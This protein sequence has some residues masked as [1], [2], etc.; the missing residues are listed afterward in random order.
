MRR[1][2]PLLLALP[3]ALAGALPGAARAQ[4]PE[5]V[6]VAVE[7]L[8]GEH[9]ARLE[10]ALALPSGPGRERASRVALALL[11]APGRATP[12]EVL[13]ATLAAGG[14]SPQAARA[15]FGPHLGDEVAAAW[16]SPRVAAA[17][18]LAELA[19][20]TADAAAVRRAREAHA[21]AH[22][23]DAE[24]GRALERSIDRVA[25]RIDPERAVAVKV[26]E[27]LAF[28]RGRLS[29]AE[30][31]RFAEAVALARYAHAGQTRDGG[32]PALLHSLRVARAMLATPG[33]EPAAVHAAVLH[34]VVEDT[35]V[36]RSE[37][38]RRLG[39]RVSELVHAVT[40]DPIERFGGDKLARDRAYYARFAASP[41]GARWL[42][43][44][45]RI[46]NINDMSGWPPEGQLRYLARTRETVVEALRAH[47]PAL[48]ARLEAELQRVEARV[49]RQLAREAPRA[50]AFE[51]HRRPDGSLRWGEVARDTAL[52]EGAGLLRF[53]MAMFL[54]ELAVVARTGDRLRVEEFFEG[55]LTTDFLVHYG[56]FTVGARAG[57]V[58][59]SRAL[60]RHLKPGFVGEVL[61]ANVSLAA[62]LL[63]ADLASGTFDGQAFALSVAALGL[64]STAVRAGVSGLRWVR[65]LRSAGTVARAGG[66]AGFVYSVLETTVV[67][68]LADAIEERAREWLDERAARAALTEAGRAFGRDVAAATSPDE[69][70][71]AAAR[72]GD[73]WTA[74]RDHLL[75]GA[76]IEDARLRERL[77]KIARRAKLLDD[78]RRAA[79][80]ALER[81]PALRDDAVRRH[82]SVDAWAE[83][84]AAEDEARVRADLEAALAAHTRA[85]DAITAA[86]YGAPRRAAPLLDGVAHLP[87]LLLGAAAGAPGDP[88]GDR[89]D[90]LARWGRDRARAGLDRAHG[91]ASPNRLQ[92]YDDQAAVLAAAAAAL[93]DRP[94]APPG[95]AEALD[96]AAARALRARDLEAG[97]AGAGGP[98][99][100][101]LV[102]A[103]E[104]R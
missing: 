47:S 103:L 18:A 68:Y 54:K 62:G 91:R 94:G 15:R 50:A 28:S 74:W 66:V 49:R 86:A 30:A 44:H 81:A 64:S 3:L 38:T 33:V 100:R 5:V 17:V 101:G 67:L 90:V 2:A 1:R 82:G 85:V 53:T 55:I 34:D 37:I 99:R 56:A 73:A 31:A 65:S 79:R 43:L 24:L 7:R 19:G 70:A 78:E 32:Q 52:R 42:K 11:E 69:V 25:S 98:A 10:A 22:E 104:G 88:W 23:V 83:A 71:A 96:E 80:A 21:R 95:A 16:S 58:A 4:D 72:Y 12:A 60:H 92:A 63:A 9:A 75:T 41:E 20:P 93:R 76:V 35:R 57:E 39:A 59:F 6:A 77:E 84:R 8:G 45:D 36:P 13:A 46:D 27:V 48:A 89:A 51:R 87:W 29:P 61:R 97:L 26:E 14:V 40:L 102:D